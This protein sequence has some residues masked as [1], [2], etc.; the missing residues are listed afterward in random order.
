MKKD[1]EHIS[2]LLDYLS[3]KLDKKARLETE[4]MLAEDASLRQMCS[5]LKQL[6]DEA[7]AVRWGEIGN[8]AHNISGSI[9]EDFQKSLNSRKILKGVKLFDS[10]VLPLPEGVRPA[11]VDTRRVKYKIG[12][13][14]L[15]LSF[16]PVTSDAYEIIGQLTG[17]VTE[18]RIRVVLKGKGRAFSTD[19][20]DFQVFCFPR[21]PV[22][23]YRLSILLNDR[24]FAAVDIE[25]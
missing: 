11:V 20:D 14:D 21:V 24:K 9:F 22:M 12:E 3:D 8:A 17:P 23:K 13:F 10:L 5:I 16:Y 6:L 1:R 4:K 25:L 18:E 7:D 19:G 15:D 2:L